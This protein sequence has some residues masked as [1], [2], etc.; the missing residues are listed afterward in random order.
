MLKNIVQL[1]V[2]IAEKN[3]QLLC[4]NDS[5]IPHV[6]EA[7]LQL[8]KYVGQI[9]DHVAAQAEKAKKDTEESPKGE[10]A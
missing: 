5:P 10:I 3:Y 1:E 4:D 8:L 9:E 7:L 6:K 2:K